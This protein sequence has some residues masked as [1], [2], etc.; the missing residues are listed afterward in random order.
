MESYRLDIMGKNLTIPFIHLR[1][2]IHT[3][4]KNGDFDNF[5]QVTTAGFENLLKI[6]ALGPISSC[7]RE[8]GLAVIPISSLTVLSEASPLTNFPVFGSIPRLPEQ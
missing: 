6:K 7:V 2:M 8:P 3:R 5:A 1:I 4:N